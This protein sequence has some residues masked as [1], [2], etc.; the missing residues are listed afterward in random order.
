MGTGGV[1][2]WVIVG[3]VAK[4]AAET[5]GLRG[6]AGTEAPREEVVSVAEATV[7]VAREAEA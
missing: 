7:A 4:T 3:R 6:V 2:G 1:P 5:K